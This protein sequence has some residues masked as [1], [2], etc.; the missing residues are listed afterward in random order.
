[1]RPFHLKFASLFPKIK[2]MILKK[3]MIFLSVLGILSTTNLAHSQTNLPIPNRPFYVEGQMGMNLSKIH[4]IAPLGQFKAG[5]NG[6]VS[7]GYNWRKHIL[8][9]TGLGYNSKGFQDDFA[10]DIPSQYISVKETLHYITIPLRTG[11]HFGNKVQFFVKQ[12]LNLDFLVQVHSSLISQD[13]MADK[14][15]YNGL[16]HYTKLDLSTTSSIGFNIP[17]RNYYIG[18]TANYNLGLCNIRKTEK[19]DP[20]ENSLPTTRNFMYSFNVQL[21]YRF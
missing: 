4:Y 9:E 14:Q 16:L 10:T 5:L 19:I 15:D 13:D 3:Y 8:I 20:V 11:L 17:V 18:S 7:L 21:G 1:M 2:I 6:G 12:S